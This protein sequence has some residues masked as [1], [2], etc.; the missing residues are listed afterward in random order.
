MLAAVAERRAV[1]YTIEANGT[2]EPI[3]TVA[4]ESQVSGVL[5]RVGFSE[6]DEVQPGPGA[7]PDRPAPYQAALQQAQG[8]LARDE[9]PAGGGQPGRQPV[10]TRWSQKEYV[11]TQQADQARAT[12]AALQATVAADSAAV[13]QA[14]LNLQYATIRRAD[15]RQAGSLLVRQGNLVRATSATPL[16]TINQI[17]PILVR[18]AVPATH[19]GIS[20]AL[21]R[22]GGARGARHPGGRH[23]REHGHPQ[24]HR[25][26]G[27]HDDRHGPPQ[28]HASTTRTARSGPASS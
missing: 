18:F 9:A 16:V 27:G 6:G 25:Q 10:S 4:V 21:P 20:P 17:Q 1:P 3:Q 12:A 19:L 5:L 2:V 13:E 24:L 28:G 26:R 15:R 23:D 7:V 8:M 11:T 22:E 14:R